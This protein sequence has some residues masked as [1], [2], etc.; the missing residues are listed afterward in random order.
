MN[1]IFMGTPSFGLPSLKKI[2]RAGYQLS[3][4]VTAPDKKQGRGMRMMSSPIKEF[5]I[6]AGIPVLQPDNLKDADFINELKR[7][8]PDLFVVIAFRILP[9]EVF[10]IPKYGTFNLHASLLPKYR[11]AAPINW[12]LINGETETG[13]TTFFLKAKVDTGDVIFRKSIPIYDDDTYGSLY[14]KLSFEGSDVVIDTIRAIEKGSVE[15]I[16]QDDALASPAPKI[17]KE[18]CRIRWEQSAEKIRNHIRGLSPYPAAF[19]TLNGKNV[20]IFDSSLSKNLSL[21]PSGQIVIQGSRFLVCTSDNLLEI[22]ELQLEGKKRLK[23]SDFI[24]GLKKSSE[25][26]FV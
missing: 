18:T 7:F 2:I 25:L 10:T 21:H 9:A 8:S 6:E 14:E 1:I 20:K 12:A 24:R 19:T 13:V 26:Q 4:V 15:T 11:G 3:A 23:A 5:A 22:K 17:T 16:N